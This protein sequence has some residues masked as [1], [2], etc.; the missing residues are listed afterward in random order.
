ML[1]TTISTVLPI[2]GK[3]MSGVFAVII[4]IWV[5]ISLLS[6]FLK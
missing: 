5:S 4:L 6:K 3:G 2:I 1:S